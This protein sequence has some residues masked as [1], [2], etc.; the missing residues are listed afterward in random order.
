V[1]V[2]DANVLSEVIRP[3]PAKA[4][5]D[6]LAAQPATQ[7][8]TT[9]ISEAEILY[10]IALLPKGRR[11]ASLDQAVR[12]MFAEDFTGRVLPFDGAAAEEFAAIAAARRREG[13]PIATFDAQIAAI[14]RA[15]GAALATRNVADFAACGIAI[16]DP[17]SA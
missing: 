10:G 8:F 6:W 16:V 14:A 13:R 17:W 7:L 9:A 11:R 15:C 12:R 2:L 3:A 1:I 5:L 4:V